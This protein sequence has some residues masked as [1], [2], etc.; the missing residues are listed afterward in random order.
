MTYRL[1]RFCKDAAQ[2]LVALARQNW[3]QALGIS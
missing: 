3:Q 1:R 2:Y